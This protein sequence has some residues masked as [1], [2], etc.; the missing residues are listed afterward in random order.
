[1][2]AKDPTLSELRDQMDELDDQLHGL[3]MERFAL[4]SEIAKAKARDGSTGHNRL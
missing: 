2:P 3:L 1:M 4:V